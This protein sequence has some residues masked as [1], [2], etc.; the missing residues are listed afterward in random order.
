MP[1]TVVV[2]WANVAV[3]ISGRNCCFAIPLMWRQ[4][5]R[6]PPQTVWCI[7]Q[8]HHTTPLG[9]ELSPL[10]Q[11]TVW[12]VEASCGSIHMMRSIWTY[13]PRYSCGTYFDFLCV[14]ILSLIILHYLNC[15]D[16]FLCLWYCDPGGKPD[17]LNYYPLRAHPTEQELLWHCLLT[18]Y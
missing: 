16:V 2:K 10:C 6:L 14:F 12:R 4:D 11:W 5:S 18:C 13:S 17:S 1:C 15:C 3:L 8:V 9:D 7:T